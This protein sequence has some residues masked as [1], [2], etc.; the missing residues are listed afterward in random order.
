MKMYK[1]QVDDFHIEFEK[2][3]SLKGEFT[4]NSLKGYEGLYVIKFTRSEKNNGFRFKSMD[5][6]NG[7]LPKPSFV[8]ECAN[9]FKSIDL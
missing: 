9:I 7:V 1:K 8:A 3:N 4:I 6:T 5:L 2:R